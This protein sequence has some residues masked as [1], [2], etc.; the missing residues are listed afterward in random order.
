MK[1][2]KILLTVAWI[3]G[4]F[5]FQQIPAYSQPR[6]K[7]L[8][9]VKIEKQD[10]EKPAEVISWVVVNQP[11]V[12]QQ[13]LK[14]TPQSFLFPHINQ[15]TP[16]SSQPAI[17]TLPVKKFE[18]KRDFSFRSDHISHTKDV[19]KVY[20]ERWMLAMILLYALG[21]ILLILTIVF[22]I[23][24]NSPL[25]IILFSILAGLCLAAASIILPLG[26]SGT[27]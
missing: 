11:V 12:V 2:P 25:L 16:R 21:L 23:T 26:L 13:P 24:M 6:Y 19:D 3:F 10:V 20:M 8:K 14:L 7:H 22:T 15:L 1:N 5:V 4:F 18:P 27:I 17:K 9:R